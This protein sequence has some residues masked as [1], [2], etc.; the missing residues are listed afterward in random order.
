[1]DNNFTVLEDLSTRPQMQMYS[2]Q[3][4]YMNQS[5]PPPPP[6]HHQPMQHPVMKE[7]GCSDILKHLSDCPICKNYYMCDYKYY[8]LI[9]GILLLVIFLQSRREK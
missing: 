6:Q 5:Q 9:I 8:W 3:N 7:M 1:M 4:P 2:S